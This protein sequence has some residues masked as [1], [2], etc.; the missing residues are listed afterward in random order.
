MHTD[1]E[2]FPHA[3]TD[4][5]VAEAKLRGVPV[6]SAAQM[7]DWLDGRNGSSFRNMSYAGNRL[8][9]SVSGAA[10]SRGLQGMLP[11][12]S[13]A[14]RLT[15]PHPQRRERPDDLSAGQGHELRVLPRRRR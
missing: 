15:E 3:G 8:R 6:V 13:G 14:G 11:A 12:S 4:A 5:I 1:Q 10:G 2:R 9:F 7:L